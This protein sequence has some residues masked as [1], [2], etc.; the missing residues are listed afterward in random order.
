MSPGR[1]IRFVSGSDGQTYYGLADS[2]LKNAE[3]LSPGHPFAPAT[4]PTGSHQPV[5]RLLS[6]LDRNDCRGIICIGL[7]YRDHADEAKMTIPTVPVVLYVSC[8]LRRLPSAEELDL[9][10][11]YSYKPI[12]ALTGPEDDLV[13][14]RASWERGGLDYEAELVCFTQC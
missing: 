10:D 12:T 1:L 4:K 5:S 7:N 6:P 14:P 9:T 2:T 13:I 11:A 3:V 8:I